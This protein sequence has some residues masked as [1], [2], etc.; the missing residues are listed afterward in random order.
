M[1]GGCP[2]GVMVKLLDNWIVV[3]E[4]E[5]KSDILHILKQSVIQ[6]CGT[7]SYNIISDATIIVFDIFVYWY[8]T[9]YRISCTI[10]SYSQI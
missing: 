10:C 2:S 5:L 1:T 6:L 9:I 8:V 7:I 3:S 4:F